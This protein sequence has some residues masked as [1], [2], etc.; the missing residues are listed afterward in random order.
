M[1]YNGQKWWWLA[2]MLLILG[3]QISHA[4]VP[5]PGPIE[6]VKLEPKTKLTTDG[7]VTMSLTIIP[8]ENCGDTI[9]YQLVP[10]PSLTV[11][12][13]DTRTVVVNADGIFETEF[14]ILVPDNDTSEI[15]VTIIDVPVPL[16]ILRCFVTTADSVE[17][18]YLHPTKYW[19]LSPRDSTKAA[20]SIKSI[21][22]RIPDSNTYRVFS[23]AYPRS[24]HQLRQM[25]E[26]E[27]EPL[28]GESVQYFRVGDDLYRRH[29]G[30]KEFTLVQ[31]RSID[32]IV[33]D[34]KRYLDSI[35]ALP[36]EAELRVC[37]NLQHA[38]HLESTKRMLD[39]L[40]EPE[41]DA[42]YHL[43]I[44]RE[45]WEELHRQGVPMMY[46]DIEDAIHKQRPKEDSDGS[47][48][49]GRKSSS[50]PPDGSRVELYNEGFNGGYDNYWVAFDNTA[51]LPCSLDYWGPGTDWTFAVWC[52][53][54]GSRTDGVDPY[55][56]GMSA[57]LYSAEIDVDGY[58]NI[59]YGWEL[60]HEID[61][62]DGLALWISFD[63][64]DWY[65]ED[66]YSGTSNG[67]IVQGRDLPNYP[68]VFFLVPVRQ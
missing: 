4:S 3:L 42:F 67:W 2:A 48:T 18:H 28:S 10:T 15:M 37:V 50:E 23:E 6:N 38:D 32:Q 56:C 11:V 62:Y 40:P 63:G 7:P 35:A 65:L 39:G 16:E 26:L 20:F 46:L 24:E 44:T 57:D 13:P 68:S 60:W 53:G 66:S 45:Q 36:A 49:Q 43:T 31:K 33:A 22:P 30:E 51:Y 12:G 34:K 19:W 5:V 59:H 14:D 58:H 55:D 29:E 1:K 41:S 52:N 21:V 27:K 8:R 64:Y 25:R 9:R 61:Q 54:E 17:Y 47:D